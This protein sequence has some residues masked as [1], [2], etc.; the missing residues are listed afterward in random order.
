MKAIS[1]LVCMI[2]ALGISISS[3]SVVCY[4]APSDIVTS[5][6]LSSVNNKNIKKCDGEERVAYEVNFDDI[7]LKSGIEVNS[8]RKTV[9]SSKSVDYTDLYGYKDMALR[10]NSAVRR[11]MYKNLYELCLEFDAS[12]ADVSAQNVP[13][14]GDCY[15]IGDIETRLSNDEMVETYFTFRN[16]F[17][18]YYWLSNVALFA[19]GFFGVSVY[20]EFAT[21]DTRNVFNKS[22]DEQINAIVENVKGLSRYEKVLFVHDYI[23]DLTTYAVD[24]NGYIIS[25]GITHSIVG[26]FQNGMSVCEGYAKALQLVLNRLGIENIFVTGKS[27]EGDN[28]QNHAW[29]MVRMD[30]GEYY[31]IDATWDD[32][33]FV[34]EKT[35]FDDFKHEE[36]FDIYYEY[37][38]TDADNFLTTHIPNK[39]TGT[40]IDFLYALPTAASG[41]SYSYYKQEGVY[42]GE[43]SVSAAYAAIRRAIESVIIEGRAV[44]HVRFGSSLDATFTKNI[45]KQYFAYPI[46]YLELFEGLDYRLCIYFFSDDTVS[47]TVYLN[48][49]TP[50]EDEVVTLKKSGNTIGS[51]YTLTGAIEAMNDSGDYTVIV[52]GNTGI[53]PSVT[54]PESGSVNIIGVP[55]LDPDDGKYY[56]SNV[57]LFG[58]ITFGCELYFESLQ[59]YGYPI[60]GSSSVIYMNYGKSLSYDD[61]YFNTVTARKIN[62]RPS[63][64]ISGDGKVDSSDLL[65]LQQCILGSATPDKQTLGYADIDKNGVIGSSDLLMLQQYILGIA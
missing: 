10:S 33:D 54:L 64:D 55:Q 59:F 48:E 30:D 35:D 25:N 22:I 62:F 15:I 3:A 63:K 4:A 19:P 18:Q 36:V 7:N 51:Y 46:W 24:D 26:V 31:Y 41:D 32:L 45:R 47:F 50:R 17:P 49:D 14:V 56:C 60:D 13:N 23:C 43:Q 42:I 2:V 57:L 65:L 11:E 58:D 27:G 40:S 20:K 44:G 21:Y 52:D 8:V 53:Y 29:N 1:R 9:R 28:W 39:S 5:D 37:F 61:G 12:N 38:L 16:D 6:E 34:T